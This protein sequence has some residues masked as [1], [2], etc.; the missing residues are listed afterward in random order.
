MRYISLKVRIQNFCRYRLR[1]KLTT[2]NFHF[3]IPSMHE[4]VSTERSEFNANKRPI[5]HLGVPVY[6]QHT[7]P[8]TTASLALQTTL[9]GLIVTH[10]LG[11]RGNRRMTSSRAVSY[12]SWV[13]KCLLPTPG[14]SWKNFDNF[15]T[16]KPCHPLPQGFLIACS[17]LKFSIL[18]MTSNFPTYQPTVTNSIHAQTYHTSTLIVRQLPI[19]VGWRDACLALLGF[20]RSSLY[21]LLYV[22]VNSFFFYPVVYL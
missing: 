4:P 22:T 10:L 14:F 20:S 21:T 9:N 17:T 13:V 2:V 12:K 18:R 11:D 19:K 8:M 7:L 15:H 16:F 1:S 5:F 3:S 6:S